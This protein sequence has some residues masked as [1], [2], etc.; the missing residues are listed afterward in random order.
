MIRKI[1]FALFCL[2]TTIARADA[3][4]CATKRG[5]DKAY[6]Q[7]RLIDDQKCWYSGKHRLDKK[8]L[9]WPT[10]A[11]R[12]HPSRPAPVRAAAS[13]PTPPAQA[14]APEPS[15]QVSVPEFAARWIDMPPALELPQQ[16][17]DRLDDDVSA[18]RTFF[19]PV[20]VAG[21]DAAMLYTD[22]PR[23]LTAIAASSMSTAGSSLMTLGWLFLASSILAAVASLRTLG[24]KQ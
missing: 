5:T 10:R 3:V 14:S 20:R 15:A 1:A 18:G 8:E 11:V 23:N 24:G 7:Y 9:R 13:A 4:E 2:M 19:A 22:P 17:Y 21:F 6:W 16:V 12:S